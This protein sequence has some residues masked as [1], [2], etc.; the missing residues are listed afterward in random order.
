[1]KALLLQFICSLCLFGADLKE[2][3]TYQTKGNEAGDVR[4]S[5]SVVYAGGEGG[6]YALKLE[7]GS[8]VFLFKHEALF[9]AA[10]LVHDG[11]LYA[12]GD[13]GSFIK[14]NAKTGKAV[15]EFKAERKITGAAV[16]AVVAGK[17]SVVF[18]SYDGKLYALDS[19]YL[20]KKK[21]FDTRNFING[22]PVADKGRIIF[23]GCD[24]IL[25]VLS[26]DGFEELCA[27]DT[28]SYI[29]GSPA[30][31]GRLVFV[32]TYDSGLVAADSE[33][34]K[35]LWAYGNSEEGAP[36]V[37]SP[38]VVGERVV[39]CDKEGT[40]HCVDFSG[41]RIWM[42]KLEDG[43]V[44]SPVLLGS[45]SVVVCDSSGNV[46]V[47]SVRTGKITAQRRCGVPF[48]GTPACIG[49]RIV[50]SGDDGRIYAFDAEG[51]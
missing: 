48:S 49:R 10:P 19:I 27:V 21:E 4:I 16:P 40:V 38:L 24:G 7:D 26:T 44:A 1:M 2:I 47:L 22:S 37:S 5:E 9:S 41:K 50:V 34:E 42:R 30:V 36:F 23:G 33:N 14:I 18:G 32:G 43:T 3:W 12:G 8:S 29:P 35:V 13:D 31:V 46:Y 6:I 39:A 20:E 11:F 25:H 45:D 15:E 28:E 51:E 17:L